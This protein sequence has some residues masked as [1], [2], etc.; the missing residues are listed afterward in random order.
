[1]A[2]S[3]LPRFDNAYN[4]PGPM[5]EYR[6]T[7]FDR[8]GP[9]AF[10]FL[11]AGG[12]SL[13]VAGMV[14]LAL[15]FRI[16]F[17]WWILPIALVA[18]ATACGCALM[19]ANA[20]GKG[21]HTVALSGA[22]TPYAEQ[23]SHEQSLV[24]R[25]QVGEALAS[26]E[27]VIARD[28]TAVDAMIRAAELYDRECKNHQRAAELLRAAQRTPALTAGKDIYVTNRLVDLLLGP[29]GDPGRALVELRKLIDRHPDSRAAAHAKTTIREIKAR[30][31]TGDPSALD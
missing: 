30:I 11:Q 6:K 19:I 24:M 23:Y 13:V 17:H 14:G 22:S 12:W 8:H 20:V 1:L 3:A 18:G 21:W 5:T 29:L 7:L 28:P 9:D 2:S 15:A 27:Q 31:H 26:F 10:L 16:G 25:G 4:T